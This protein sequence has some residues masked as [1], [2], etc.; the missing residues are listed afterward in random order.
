LTLLPHLRSCAA[1]ADLEDPEDRTAR[2]TLMEALR[3]VLKEMLLLSI[4]CEIAS[5]SKR[6]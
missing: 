6:G 2:E 5:P 1:L 3:M 4:A